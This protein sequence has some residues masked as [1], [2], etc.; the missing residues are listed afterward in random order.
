MLSYKTLLFNMVTTIN[1][2]FFMVINKSLH[3]VLVNI[4]TSGGDPLSLSPLLKHTLRASLCSHLL[5]SLHKQS[6][7]ISEYQWVPYFPHGENKWHTFA[8]YAVPHQTSFCQTAPLLP[9]VARQ[10]HVMEWCQEGSTST[11][12]PPTSASDIMGK[13]R[14][15]YFQSHPHIWD[16][17][18]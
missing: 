2:A 11:A 18:W 9:S 6:S 8:P 13:H 15:Y 4:C 16:F 14:R 17:F 10:Q 5:F 1:C 12:I 3:S 7:S